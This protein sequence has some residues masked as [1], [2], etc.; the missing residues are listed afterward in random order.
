[1][2]ARDAGQ[3]QQ[4]KSVEVELPDGTTVPG[5]IARVGRVAT[6]GS[7]ERGDETDATIEVTV[8]L[9]GAEGVDAFDQAPVIVRRR[10]RGRA[11]R[12]RGAGRRAAGAGR[13]RLRARGRR[14]P[15]RGWCRVEVG[16]FADGYVQV[17][18]DGIDEGTR[19]VQ[20]DL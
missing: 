15:G 1:M 11:R 18:G 16:A 13:R 8:R 19:V 10:D 4:G 3:V 7:D 14:R 2:D 5:R 12:A 9:D 6:G 17:T 20:A